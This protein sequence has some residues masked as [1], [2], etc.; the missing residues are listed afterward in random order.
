[1]VDAVVFWEIPNEQRSGH[2]L[3]TGIT[4]GAGHAQLDELIFEAEN[5]KAK[6][7]MYA[8]TQREKV[9]ILDSIRRC[10]WNSEVNPITVTVG[11]GLL[12]E[13]N[14]NSGLVKHALHTC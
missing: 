12:L 13:H 8:E 10:E 11:D 9:E 2:L 1:M 4:V 7:D 6:R 14:F 3:L 5:I